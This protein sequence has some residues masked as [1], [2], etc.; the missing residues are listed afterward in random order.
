LRREFIEIN[1]KQNEILEQYKV[2]KYCIER[3]GYD[4]YQV[5][6]ANAMMINEDMVEKFCKN[7]LNKL[8]G[9]DHNN[10][11]FVV[12]YFGSGKSEFCVNFAIQ[13]H[14]EY[15]CDLDVINPYFRSRQANKVLSEHGIKT[16]SSI[17]KDAKYLDMP[18]LSEEI[19]DLYKSNKKIIYDLGGSFQG[20][21]LIKQFEAYEKQPSTLLF[22]INVYR[23]ETDSVEKIINE[24]NKI[25]QVGGIKVDGLI[26]NSNLLSET[27]AEHLL[28][29]QEIIRQV[30]IKTNIPI[31]YS[32]FNDSL[33]IN[34]ALDGEIIRLKMYLKQHNI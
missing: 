33:K 17:E 16:I 6:K 9:N 28:R 21:K 3:D 24:I 1:K 11:Y 5:K 20:A 2:I 7:E 32:C 19:F 12:G 29:G 14:F 15:L 23:K 25:E 8:K 18:L 30:S 31:L 13:K 4:F 27:S 22:I 10:I 26:N 34:E